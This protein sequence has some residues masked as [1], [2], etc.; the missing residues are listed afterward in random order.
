MR[1]PY[2]AI[3]LGW[4]WGRASYAAA[5]TIEANRVHRYK[6]KLDDGGCLYT[7]SDQPGSVVQRNWCSGQPNLPLTLTLT[8]PTAH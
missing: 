2:S 8:L 6:L 1:S 5:N 4:G 3:S 7:L